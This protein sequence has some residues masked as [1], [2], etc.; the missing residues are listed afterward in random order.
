MLA[1]TNDLRAQNGLAPLVVSATLTTVAATYTETMAVNDWFSHQ[2]P[3]GSTLGTRADAAGYT[4]WTY[5]A[6]NLYKGYYLDSPQSILQA[7]IDS[8]G[9]L[10]NML[11]PRVTEIG[12]GCYVR[13]EYR[14][15]SQEFGS[16]S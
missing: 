11:S 12:V 14:W 6:E 16:R 10:E 13:G 8:P 15:C 5:L 7:W 1:L 4:G 9:H 3:D 2:G